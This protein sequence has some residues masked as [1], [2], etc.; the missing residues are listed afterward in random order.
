MTFAKN[1]RSLDLLLGVLMGLCQQTARRLRDARLV[2]RTVTLKLRYGDFTT[3]TRQDTVGHPTDD[4]GEIYAVASRLLTAEREVDERAVRLLGVGLT[5]LLQRTQI[6]LDL[7]A[8]AD[9]P[10]RAGARS[11]P[12]SVETPS[13]NPRQTA[14]NRTLDRL[15]DRFGHGAVSRARVHRAPQ[16][17]DTDDS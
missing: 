2:G 17:D 15:E 5:G 12:A 13:I 6:N 3:I 9:G 10:R 16:E 4:A 14:L 11:S 8:G 1:H 7:F